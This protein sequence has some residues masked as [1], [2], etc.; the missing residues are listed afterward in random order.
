MVKLGRKQYLGWAEETTAGTAEAIANGDYHL[1]EDVSIELTGD[2][3]ERVGNLGSL[4]NM[5]GVTGSIIGTISFTTEFRGGGGTGTAE[6][7]DF[8]LWKASG[9]RCDESDYSGGDMV[10]DQ[11][12]TTEFK[13]VTF[14]YYDDGMLW[15]FKG[16]VGT[17]VFTLESGAIGK[18][19][20][21]FTGM[22]DAFPADGTNPTPTYNTTVP[23][24][25]QNTT[26]TL[27]A[28]TAF[29]VC[30][31]LEFDLGNEINERRDMTETYGYAVPQITR[32]NSI[33]SMSVEIPT[34]ANY[35][36]NT[37]WVNKT[38]IDASIAIGSATYNTQ[39]IAW[40]MVL[41]GA[42]NPTDTDGLMMF[43]V[44]FSLVTNDLAGDNA[45]TITYT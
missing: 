11:A 28:G 27:D 3:H 31:T 8:P 24:V 5:A 1:V 17:G 35:D 19:A 12:L 29:G 44:P 39:T 20:W 22:I 41:T 10:L 38:K 25:C 13:T 32:R 7:V 21:T 42:P 45:W 6:P 18:M 9:F 34:V 30:K 36:W 43:D 4:D 37:K 15:E 26:L 2:E 23:P 16:S 40:D 33:G 14:N